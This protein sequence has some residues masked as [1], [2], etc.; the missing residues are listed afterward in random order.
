[1]KSEEGSYNENNIKLGTVSIFWLIGAVF[2]VVVLWGANF[3]YGEFH[4]KDKVIAGQFGDMFGA[5]NAL[6]SGLA[7]SGVCYAILLQRNEIRISRKEIEYTKSIL[8]EQK[9]HLEKQNQSINKQ[10]FEDTFFKMLNLMTEITASIQMDNSPYRS[11][12]V[13][14]G[15]DAIGELIRVIKS[16]S[17]I[18]EDNVMRNYEAQYLQNQNRIGH[19]FRILYNIFS[20]IDSSDIENKKFYA[21]I[22]RAQLSNAEVALLF[23]NC[24]TD[25]GRNFKVFV[26]K[27]G[28]FKNV[29]NDDI[30]DYALKEQF[31]ASAFGRG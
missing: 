8:D 1:M 19:Y 14:F 10:S 30:V 3:W 26:E 4:L 11:E 23:F 22:L 12:H 5:V 13:L 20:F 24:L 7:F 25:R 29:S 28:L 18:T 31:S 16:H 6:F 27:Y 17:S 15:K 2:V 9:I 21:K